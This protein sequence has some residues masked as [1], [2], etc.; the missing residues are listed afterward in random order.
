MMIAIYI[1]CQG[2]QHLRFSEFSPEFGGLVQN[3]PIVVV[4]GGGGVVVII[5][6]V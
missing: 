4:V 6:Y 5:M 1:V 3:L 2:S